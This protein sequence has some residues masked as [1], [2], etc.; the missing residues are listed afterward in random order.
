MKAELG[1]DEY[2]LGL[3]YL[4]MAKELDSEDT[5]DMLSREYSVTEEQYPKVEA[6]MLHNCLSTLKPS[7]SSVVFVLKLNLCRMKNHER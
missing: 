7:L 2:I 3:C 6:L 1:T 5:L 4:F